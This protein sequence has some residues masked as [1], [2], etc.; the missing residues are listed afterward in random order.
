MLT[1]YVAFNVTCPHLLT[2]SLA[3]YPHANFIVSYFIK[4][5]IVYVVF[6]YYE[7][8]Q[9]K[10]K[11]KEN[12]KLVAFFKSYIEYFFGKIAIVSIIQITKTF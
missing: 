10:L 2:N 1:K 9:L 4:V 3:G 6:S 7:A 12:S 8:W 11:L 5:V